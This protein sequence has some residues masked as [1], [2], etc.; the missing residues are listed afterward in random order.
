MR[1]QALLILATVAVLTSAPALAQT[2]DPNY[3]IC[4][5]AYR[6]GGGYIDCSYTS[7][8]QCNATASGRAAQCYANPY[9]AYAPMRRQSRRVY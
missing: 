3:P 6:L 1:T 4:L 8:A 5:Q 7:L 9:F 2:Y